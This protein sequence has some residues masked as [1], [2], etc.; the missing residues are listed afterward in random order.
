MILTRIL[1]LIVFL[2]LSQLG[3]CQTP[4]ETVTQ[5]SLQRLPEILKNNDFEKIQTVCNTI[6][7]AC[8]N[9]ELALRLEILIQII[10]KEN[11]STAIQN[12]LSN[13]Y[14]EILITRYDDSTLKN[15]EQ[16]YA[17][18]PEK[19]QFF[20]LKSPIDALIKTKAKALLN[21]HNYTLNREELALLFLFA[22]Y[23]D[24]FYKEI[25]KRK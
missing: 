22:D 15:A 1:S 11:A 17:S 9:S 12:Y 18:N 5:A 6:Q 4:C 14:E 23:I 3:I 19:Y 2:G 21:S 25:D 24:D 20:P 8:P 7:S 16:L 10:Q 13:N